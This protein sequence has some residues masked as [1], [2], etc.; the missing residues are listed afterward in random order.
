MG[1]G[2]DSGGNLDQGSLAG[3]FPDLHSNRGYD[4]ARQNVCSQQS[5]PRRRGVYQPGGLNAW[6]TWGT[7]LEARSSGGTS[8][9]TGAISRPNLECQ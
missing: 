8:G 2:A 9:R 6:T 3:A 7:L 4:V 5:V 1:D